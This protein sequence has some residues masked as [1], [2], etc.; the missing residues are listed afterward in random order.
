[1]KLNP[2]LLWQK[3]HSTRK[4]LFTN[5]LALN[6]RKKLVRCYTWSVALY[7]VEN[8]TLRRE[9]QIHLESSKTWCWRRM[10]KICW[11]DSVKNERTLQTA[12]KYR[13]I[14]R[15]VPSRHKLPGPSSPEGGPRANYVMYVFVL[16]SIR[17][18]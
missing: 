2:G 3:Q 8:W 11:T 9:H 6:L 17:C 16:R 4:T 5:K 13:N 10:E 12:N 14:Q 18:N 15:T 7:S 1:M